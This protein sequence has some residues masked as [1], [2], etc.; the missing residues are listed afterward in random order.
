MTTTTPIKVTTMDPGITIRFS[1]MPD[2][3][4]SSVVVRRS[5]DLAAVLRVMLRAIRP[6]T[7]QKA[8]KT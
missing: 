5:E 4:R 8:L 6:A 2:R 7:N 1:K 3:S